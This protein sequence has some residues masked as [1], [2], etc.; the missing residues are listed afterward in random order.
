MKKL[1]W[2]IRGTS[3]IIKKISLRMKMLVIMLLRCWER[4]TRCM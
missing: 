4:T 1:T 3:D 2:D